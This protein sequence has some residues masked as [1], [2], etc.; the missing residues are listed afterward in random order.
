MSCSRLDLTPG[1]GADF[2][3]DSGYQESSYPELKL[4]RA[5]GMPPLQALYHSISQG[6]RIPM[7]ASPTLADSCPVSYLSFEST[8]SHR[9]ATFSSHIPFESS[10]RPD[11][12]G[13]LPDSIPGLAVEVSS[14]VRM[15][16]PGG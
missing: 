6:E 3:P 9:H 5:T 4:Q 12:N 8:D 10:R 11:S 15:L 2:L 16:F 7:R 13:V 14:F 1:C